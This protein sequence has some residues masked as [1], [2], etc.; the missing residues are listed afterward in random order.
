MN[1]AHRT[2]A[3]SRRGHRLEFDYNTG[4]Y[5]VAYYRPQYNRRHE[6]TGEERIAVSRAKLIDALTVVFGE[7]ECDFEPATVEHYLRS[8]AWGRDLP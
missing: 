1:L 7:A 6:Q 5:R 4:R 3:L 8:T 2:V